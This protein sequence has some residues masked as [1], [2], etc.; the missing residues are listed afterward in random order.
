MEDHTLV[1]QGIDP[2]RY[3]VLTRTD[4]T[5]SNLPG[6]G[7]TLDIL[8]GKAARWLR[9]PSGV[10]HTEAGPSSN[11]QPVSAASALNTVVS[12]HSNAGGSIH[13]TMVLA[14]AHVIAYSI[15]TGT[16]STISD[17]QGHGRTGDRLFKH[18]SQWLD[19]KL[20]ISGELFGRGPV[21][22]MR[23]LCNRMIKLQR[24]VAD[25]H[26]GCDLYN[27]YRWKSDLLPSP[28]PRPLSRSGRV[29]VGRGVD[30]IIALRALA[31]RCHQCCDCFNGSLA[32]DVKVRRYCVRLVEIT[33]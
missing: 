22:P 5:I 29:S 18:V 11:T 20:A 25:G 3:S 23:R 19:E 13:A 6:A 14:G 17:L 30:I 4:S 8:I 33:R 2:D 27:S 15:L 28:V 24:S 12:S 31:S 10:A 9:R 32:S 21:V 1:P 16:D 7:G 26:K